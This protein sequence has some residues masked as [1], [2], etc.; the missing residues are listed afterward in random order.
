MSIHLA[1]DDVEEREIMIRAVAEAS[2]VT[3]VTER[4][5]RS[6]ERGDKLTSQARQA[7]MW[8]AHQHGLSYPV[9]GRFFRRNHTTVMHAVKAAQERINANMAHQDAL[10]FKTTRKETS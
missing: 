5:I 9:I 3:G 6:R 1:I 8:Q 10:T 2:A 4:E 7:A